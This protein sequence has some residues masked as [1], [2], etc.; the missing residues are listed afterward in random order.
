MTFVTINIKGLQFTYALTNLKWY[1]FPLSFSQPF[2]FIERGW[3]STRARCTILCVNSALSVNLPLH[4]PATWTSMS[5]GNT[6][7]RRMSGRIYVVALREG[8]LSCLLNYS[9]KFY[10]FVFLFVCLTTLGTFIE[11][12]WLVH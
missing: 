1:I 9:P 7:R 10:N 3:V 8:T 6:A 12:D 4:A 11:F 2:F 5:A